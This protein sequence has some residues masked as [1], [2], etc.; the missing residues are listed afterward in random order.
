MEHQEQQRLK[1]WLS[2]LAARHR[3]GKPLSHLTSQKTPLGKQVIFYLPSE[4]PAPV[5]VCRDLKRNQD[6]EMKFLYKEILMGKMKC[7][8]VINV[9]TFL[10]QM[11]LI[12]VNH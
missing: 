8:V 7:C 9:E 1:I 10:S 11:Q 12:L 3:L 5:S 6:E 2:Q 4:S